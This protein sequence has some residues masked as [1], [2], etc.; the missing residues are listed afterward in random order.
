MVKRRRSFTLE[1]KAEAVR[2]V[3]EKHD[4]IR[5]AAD[6]LGRGENLVRRW[7]DRLADSANDVEGTNGTALH[8]ELKRLRAEN[9]RLLMDGGI[10]DAT[11]IGATDVDHGVAAAAKLVEMIG[12]VRQSGDPFGEEPRMSVVFAEPR[13][14]AVERVETGGG[15]DSRL[16]H[17]PAEAPARGDRLGDHRLY[18]HYDG[19]WG[20][21]EH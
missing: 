2:L 1:F 5:E 11:V 16:P 8:E 20:R 3:T 19:T 17:R 21:M 10:I 18:Q 14:I 9:K 12:D 4:S 6:S 7:K 13:D 15:E